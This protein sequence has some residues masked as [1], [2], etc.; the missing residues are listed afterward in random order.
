MEELKIPQIIHYCWFGNKEKPKLVKKCINSWAIHLPE[1]EIREWNEN[2]FEIASNAF[3]KNAFNLKKYAFVSD[4]VRLYALYNFG[5]IYLDT[6]VEVF[7]SFNDLLDNNSFWGF[8]EG[9]YVAT[10]TIGAKKNNLFIKNLLDS[11]TSIEFSEEKVLTNVAIVSQQLKNKGLKLNGVHQEIPDVG[12]FF[13]QTYFSP[14]DYINCRN[15]KT[16]NSYAMHHYYK[17]WLPFTIRIKGKI[18]KISSIMVGGENIARFRRF[19]SKE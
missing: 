19:V 1:Y 9:N 4:Y 18:K 6:D 16:D 15:L 14:Y 12:T 13:P 7:K 10:S 8:E 5:G 2:N 3:V 11:Y 17:S